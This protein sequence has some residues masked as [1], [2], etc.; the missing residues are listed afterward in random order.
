MEKLTTKITKIDP[1]WRRIIYGALG[2]VSVPVSIFIL[3]LLVGGLWRFFVWG[4]NV[5][6]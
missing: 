3:G 6:G 1:L 2:L 5:F 4:F